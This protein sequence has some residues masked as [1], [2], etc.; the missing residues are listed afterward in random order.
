MF[1]MRFAIT[2]IFAIGVA[3]ASLSPSAKAAQLQSNTAASYEKYIRLTEQRIDEELR[4][5]KSDARF[6]TFDFSSGDQGRQL[7]DS[8][9]R[10]DIHVEK[11]RT[12]EGRREIEA[13][14]GLIHH[15]LGAA[16]VPGVK[17]DALQK[18]LKDYGQH[19]RYFPEIEK[20]KLISANGDTFQFYYRL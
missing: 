20:S 18:W 2:T 6:M 12:R 11:M 8:L 5:A 13:D 7:R 14:D 4:L 3:L 16:F 15:W 1:I 9:K 17:L 19:E 10:G